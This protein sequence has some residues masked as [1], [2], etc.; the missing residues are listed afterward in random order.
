MADEVHELAVA[1]RPE[2]TQET[3]EALS[4]TREEFSDTADDVG[5]STGLMSDFANKFTGA[6]IVFAGAF[7]TMVGAIASRMP[8]ISEVFAGLDAVLTALALRF[9]RL[10]RD[11]ARPFIQTL[12]DL[13][14]AIVTPGE[15]LR[16]LRLSM[17]AVIEGLPLLA[18]GFLAPIEAVRRLSDAVGA[19]IG[20]IAGDFTHFITTKIPAFE[21][22]FAGIVD[23]LKDLGPRV[24]NAVINNI[25]NPFIE[26]INDLIR[27]VNRRLDRNISL[28]GLLGTMDLPSD[29]GG[30]RP[31]RVSGPRRQTG[32]R[33]RGPALE[34]GGE[35]VV[36]G[37]LDNQ[38]NL[39]SQT[40]AEETKPFT[41]KGVLGG[42]RGARLR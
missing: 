2:G 20:Q 29:G 40:V 25:V 34:S 35:V 1:I 13:S 26:T 36:T 22:A 41:V 30:G 10:T 42:G 6:G 28:I 19:M 37:T 12:F 16:A 8:I 18:K 21:A 27:E 4:D 3:Q 9:D 31:G 17:D 24:V 5:E 38:T 33:D 11:S 23:F 39:D 7:G 14:E 15:E 32:V